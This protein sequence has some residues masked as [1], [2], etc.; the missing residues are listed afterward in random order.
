MK[1]TIFLTLV[2]SVIL[3]AGCSGQTAPT[4]VVG[5]EI[6]VSGGA[7]TNVSVPELQTMLKNKDFVFVNVHIPFS[8]DIPQTDLSI[9]YD[10][11]STNLDQFP[12][13]KNA[14]IVLYCSSDTMSTTASKTLVE[15]GYT[16]VWNLEGGF[17]AWKAAGL[18]FE[19]G[20]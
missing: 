15:M 10:Q 13:D 11:I 8:G 20:K 6:P 3:F 9:P 1:R 2:L 12:A 5:K 17:S 4:E 19:S 14:K 16:N 7:Y 18:P